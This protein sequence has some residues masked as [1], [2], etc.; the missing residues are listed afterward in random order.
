MYLVAECLTEDGRRN[1]DDLVVFHHTL[2]TSSYQRRGDDTPIFIAI[3]KGRTGRP[4]HKLSY[5][6]RSLGLTPKK[7]LPS[8]VKHL[9]SGARLASTP[10]VP[11]YQT[12]VARSD[13]VSP[14][15]LCL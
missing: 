13:Q 4:F 1:G 10:S 3:K 9:T 11:D 12:S 7:R 2:K 14:S 15:S 8:P 6:L 5:L